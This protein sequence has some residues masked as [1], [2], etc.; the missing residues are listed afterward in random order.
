MPTCIGHV[1]DVTE[2]L[3]IIDNPFRPKPLGSGR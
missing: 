1:P 3:M 2:V